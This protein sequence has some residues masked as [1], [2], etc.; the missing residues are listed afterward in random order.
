MGPSKEIVFKKL[1]SIDF[2][3][4]H[5][6]TKPERVDSKI[7]KLNSLFTITTLKK[8]KFDG[9]KPFKNKLIKFNLLESVTKEGIPKIIIK[10]KVVNTKLKDKNIQ[11]ISENEL[12][13]DLKPVR[14]NPFKKYQPTKTVTKLEDKKEKT[15]NDID[16]LLNELYKRTSDL[17]QSDVFIEKFS[18]LNDKPR[19][20]KISYKT[21]D[22]KNLYSKLNEVSKNK[23]N[24]LESLSIE[25]L[26]VPDVFALKDNIENMDSIVQDNFTSR[27]D[28]V[29]ET[30]NIPYFIAKK[31]GI[32]INEVVKDNIK[33]IEDHK[34]KI[35]ENK[36]LDY[37]Q[38]DMNEFK[39]KINEDDQVT[40]DLL[41]KPLPKLK[42]TKSLNKKEIKKKVIYLKKTTQKTETEDDKTIDYILPSD[43]GKGQYIVQ[44]TT[45][46]PTTE[47][48][49]E[50][51][52][53]PSLVYAVPVETLNLEQN[54]V[55]EKY[56]I[57]EFTFVT[58]SYNSEHGL[59]YNIIQPELTS[60]QK[61][62]YLEIKKS[63]FNTI[64]K[65]YTLFKGDK[66][67]IDNYIEK[68]YRLSLDRLSYDVGSL[69]KKLYLKFIRREFTGLG[70]LTNLL[71]D[72]KILEVSCAGEK[73]NITIYHIDYGLLKT[74][75]RFD[76][77]PELNKFVLSLTK[78]MGLFV[79]T[80]HPI[81]HGYLP[82]GYKIEGLYSVGDVSSKGSSFVIKKYLENPLTP[83]SLMKTGVGVIDLFTYIWEAIDEG[84]RIV[85][86]GKDDSYII[87][88]SV[89]LLFPDK[90]IITV[91]SYD[92]IKLPQKEWIKRTF[93]GSEEVNKTMLLEQSISE[94]PNYLMLDEF[95]KN[96]F[97]LSWYN[98]NMF[99]IDPK[100]TPELI[101]NIKLINQKAIIIDL[102]RVKT[103]LKECMQITSV[104]EINNKK[105]Y[106]I[107]ELNN[108]TDYH[109][110]LL[111]S[112]LDV[113]EFTKK[114]KLVRWLVDA[115][116]FDYKDFN[117]IISEYSIDSK[118]IIER[119]GIK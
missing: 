109:I 9:Y 82:S 59:F 33:K 69:E 76:D 90:K 7:E 86:S 23:D 115:K 4:L 46:Y 71:L 24:K 104:R 97:D 65:N 21:Y 58:I 100:L 63:F 14:N 30:T 51:S 18:F 11:Y 117:N 101:E 106:K 50:Q 8:E 13:C 25:Q 37:D 62:E 56:N 111:S 34:K 20:S 35:N 42:D 80:S 107:I 61:K 40:K 19:V 73:T 68:T 27:E 88:N 31:E 41:N 116:I 12:K 89:G 15:E 10:N 112:S 70:I 48:D 93:T 85:L 105:E 84:Y 6:N 92:R 81:I 72:K 74:N 91:Q 83:V 36:K 29:K 49:N 87:F 57:D 2:K 44:E 22:V 38:I 45:P 39:K 17:E 95:T 98:I 102:D 119:L 43:S 47:F 28:N 77:V 26:S 53:Y 118:K 113:V 78:N 55:Y 94:R 67:N 114:K 96:V 79:N 110:N 108:N 3:D 103:K 5:N 75:L 64:D 54:K 1:E 99:A 66:H 32:V 60:D 16:D 52:K